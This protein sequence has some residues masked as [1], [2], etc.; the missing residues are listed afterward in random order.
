MSTRED[1]EADHLENVRDFMYIIPEEVDEDEDDEEW[2]D[3]DDAGLS[4]FPS[5]KLL[6]A[7]EELSSETELKGRGNRLEV[8]PACGNHEVIVLT[9]EGAVKVINKRGRLVEVLDD[10]S[11]WS[12][13]S[14]AILLAGR[15]LHRGEQS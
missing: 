7:L 11:D 12:P 13:T 4:E 15:P 8:T 6:D 14:L 10:T 1:R 3:S 9:K 2:L 5:E